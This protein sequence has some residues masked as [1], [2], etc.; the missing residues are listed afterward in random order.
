MQKMTFKSL[1]FVVLLTLTV[2]MGGCNGCDSPTEPSPTEPPPAG[3]GGIPHGS[4]GCPS[5]FQ[6]H[7]GA[8]GVPV[9]AWVRV[10]NAPPC[11]GTVRV[12]TIPKVVLE[13]R[14]DIAERINFLVRV[15]KDGERPIRSSEDPI[16]N[17]PWGV[18]GGVVPRDQWVRRDFGNLIPPGISASSKPK[19]MGLG[20]TISERG[21]VPPWFGPL[22]CMSTVSTQCNL[23]QGMVILD[24]NVVD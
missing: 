4:E 1:V 9:N 6:L 17:Y 16:I 2:S 18:L 3:N 20:V 24:L 15:S 5:E 13:L 10:V 19:I 11:G 14:Q 22:D 8:T 23:G 21:S 7:D 12:N